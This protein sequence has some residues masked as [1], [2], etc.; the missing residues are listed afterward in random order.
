MTIKILILA[1]TRPE[2]IKLAPLIRQIEED[3]EISLIF[4]HSGQHYDRNLFTQLLE[5]LELPYPEI[6]IGVGSGTHSYQTGTLIQEIEKI[7]FERNPDLVIAQ[8]DTN[9]VMASA[10]ATRKINKCF[11]HLEAGIRSFDKRMPEEVN[12]VVAGVCSMY[13]LAPTERA[14]INLLFEGVNR[15]NIFIVGNT[16]VDAVM[17]TKNI[18]GRRSTILRELD[19]KNDKPLVLITLHRPANVDNKDN[20]KS[21]VDKLEE[22][23]D[24]QFIFSVH[25]R[26]KKNLLNFNLY[27]SFESHSHILLTEPLGYLD[28]FKI[29]SNSLCVLTDSGGIQEEASILRVPCITLR[30]NTERPETLEFNSNILIGMNM[31]KLELELKKVLS[32][33]DYLTGNSGQNPFGDGKSSERIVHIIKELYNETKFNIKSSKLWSNI[34]KQIL[35]CIDNKDYEKSVKEYEKS[36]RVN[37]RLIFDK[38]GK[39]H[40]P[41]DNRKLRKDDSLLL[42]IE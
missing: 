2:L 27:E 37:I 38:S 3:P 41:H 31:K 9:T 1:G 39:P 28:F 34:P 35:K 15:E 29:F 12:R 19:L 10:L 36:H 17:Q 30:N 24:F 18:A 26:T 4:V 40:F 16:I 42:N 13:H 21:F 22:L 5:D 11:M 7:V 33:S 6:N 20:L 32:N 14:A 25:P 23:T 8:G